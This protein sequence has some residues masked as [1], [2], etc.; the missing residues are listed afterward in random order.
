MNYWLF[1]AEEKP[2]L[3]GDAADVSF[4]HNMGFSGDDG[5]GYSLSKRTHFR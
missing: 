4:E 5:A 3:G 2:S 1:N